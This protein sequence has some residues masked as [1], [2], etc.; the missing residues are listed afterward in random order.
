MADG[1]CG[2]GGQL[3][4]VDRAAEAGGDLGRDVGVDD[5]EVALGAVGVDADVE[6]DEGAGDEVALLERLHAVG[7]AVLEGGGELLRAKAARGAR[8]GGPGGR[9]RVER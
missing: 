4:G 6:D 2:A 9:R 7:G 5:V 3:D 8:R 1:G